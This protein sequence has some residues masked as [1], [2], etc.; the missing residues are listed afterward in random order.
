MRLHSV[1]DNLPSFHYLWTEDT[2]IFNYH[3]WLLHKILSLRFLQ[4]KYCFSTMLLS[5]LN[6][7]V[8]LVK[9]RW[10]QTRLLSYSRISSLSTM[11][12]YF[13]DVQGIWRASTSWEIYKKEFEG[14][15]ENCN[16]NSCWCKTFQLFKVSGVYRFSQQVSIVSKESSKCFWSCV[17]ERC[18]CIK[19]KFLPFWYTTLLIFLEPHF[20]YSLH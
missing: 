4:P 20:N 6:K 14:K 17:W 12:F 2:S 18:W 5:S 9:V 3:F 7:S 10:T 1:L 11:S 15:R 13:K 8:N 16:L 19:C